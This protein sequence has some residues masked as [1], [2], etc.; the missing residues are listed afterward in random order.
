MRH[1]SIQD[2]TIDLPILDKG[3]GWLNVEHNGVCV[4]VGHH[5]MRHC[6]IALVSEDKNKPTY[7]GGFMDLY[8]RKN[9]S[10]KDLLDKY[11]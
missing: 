8:I 11:L 4:Y 6:L 1:V 3:D 7:K 5:T 10:L 9:Q 2:V